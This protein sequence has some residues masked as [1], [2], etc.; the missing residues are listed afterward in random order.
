MQARREGGC[1]GC[2]CTPP[3]TAEVH[4]FVKNWVQGA[5][6]APPQQTAEV[7][8]FLIAPPPTP[9]KNPGYGPAMFI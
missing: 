4:F 9:V 5:P 2:A 1:E 7:H 8:F 6:I 3:Q